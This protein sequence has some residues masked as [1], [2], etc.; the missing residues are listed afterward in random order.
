MISN[1]IRR[2]LLYSYITLHYH[3][4]TTY[5][6]WLTTKL[7]FQV[8]AFLTGG[9]YDNLLWFSSLSSSASWCLISRLLELFIAKSSKL[10]SFFQGGGVTQSER[11]GNLLES[12]AGVTGDGVS[13]WP[14]LSCCSV[15]NDSLIADIASKNRVQDAKAT[16]IG[17]SI[18]CSQRNIKIHDKIREVNVEDTHMWSKLEQHKFLKLNN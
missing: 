17:R 4:I 8:A 5:I 18:S 14:T 10:G 11:P 9:G 16:G 15:A 13:D 6:H 12:L 3:H 1:F 2:L 7:R